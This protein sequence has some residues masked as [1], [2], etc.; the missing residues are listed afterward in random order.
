MSIVIVDVLA[1]TCVS[2][3]GRLR[4][5]DFCGNRISFTMNLEKPE[6]AESN[7]RPERVH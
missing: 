2:D 3:A 5:K 1:G 4:E 6:A 7:V